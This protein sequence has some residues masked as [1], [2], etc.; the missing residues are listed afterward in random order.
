MGYVTKYIGKQGD[1]PM[2]R[3]YYS[4]GRLRQPTKIYADLEWNELKDQYCGQAVE[5]DIPGS[6]LMVIHTKEEMK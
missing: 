2:G 5:F 4:G 1:R 6:K 3:W